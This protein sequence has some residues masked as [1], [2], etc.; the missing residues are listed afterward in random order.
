MAAREAC[1]ENSRRMGDEIRTRACEREFQQIVECETAEHRDQRQAGYPRFVEPSNR[2][3]ATANVMIKRCSAS[4]IMAISGHKSL[5]EV[6][7]YC[8]AADQARMARQ[9]IAA[10]TTRTK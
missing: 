4:E 1:G 6:Q 2:Y 9:G 7:R 10:I 8:A 3:P 5:S